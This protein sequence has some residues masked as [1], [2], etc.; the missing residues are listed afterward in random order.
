MRQEFTK[1]TKIAAWERAHG[2]CEQCRSKIF[3]RAEYDHIVEDYIGGDN[4]LE[5]CR[6]LCPKCHKAK[7][8]ESRPAIDKTRRIIEKRA[9]VRQ[10]RGFPKPPPDYDP[11]TR[12]R[13]G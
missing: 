10:G 1:K 5:N 9:G 12:T 7:T 4:S 2:H 6:V 11:W 13:R 8:R 3:T